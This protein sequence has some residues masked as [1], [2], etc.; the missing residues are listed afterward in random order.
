MPDEIPAKRSGGAPLRSK[1]ADFREQFTRLGWDVVDHYST[2]WKVVA[3][4]VDEEGREN[5]QADLKAY[6]Q[7][8]ALRSRFAAIIDSR[9]AVIPADFMAYVAKHASAHIDRHNKLC[10]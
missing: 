6:R 5:L 3:R 8:L 9:S 7:M 4:W 10:R 2:S 1:P